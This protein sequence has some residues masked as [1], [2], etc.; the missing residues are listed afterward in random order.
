MKIKVEY[1]YYKIFL[2]E[3][4]IIV[5]KYIPCGYEG[6]ESGEEETTVDECFLDGGYCVS[7]CK[8]SSPYIGIKGSSIPKNC[9]DVEATGNDGDNNRCGSHCVYDG[10]QSVNKCQK[11]CSGHY[12]NQSGICIENV[13]CGTRTPTLETMRCGAG[14]YNDDDEKGRVS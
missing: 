4:I 5:M 11:N 13:D 10:T 3:R 14:C 6:K 8:D 12:K 9:T 7:R 2:I 1:T